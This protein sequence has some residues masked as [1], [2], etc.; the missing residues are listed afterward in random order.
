MFE[1]STSVSRE[2]SDTEQSE[3]NGEL[4]QQLFPIERHQSTSDKSFDVKRQR[5]D[6]IGHQQTADMST[7]KS[8]QSC[9]TDQTVMNDEHE[10]S[11]RDQSMAIIDVADRSFDRSNR[12]S[13]DTL[14]LDQSLLS[15]V[16]TL[17]LEIVDTGNRF[18]MSFI[19]HILDDIL[20][21][22]CSHEHS[23]L[24]NDEKQQLDTSD[25]SI[26]NDKRHNDAH[27]QNVVVDRVHYQVGNVV[28]SHH[29][30]ETIDSS[31]TISFEEKSD[32]NVF[33]SSNDDANAFERTYLKNSSMSTDLFHNRQ[34]SMDTTYYIPG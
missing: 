12:F 9:T 4:C 18:D 13:A 28:D 21:H 5:I 14:D 10:T 23:L 7:L 3:N 34:S 22:P 33:S 32:M 2:S 17:E 31:P 8:C 29:G 1:H 25:S 16:P 19:D 30:E 11:D 26:V 15:I 6:S 24:T 20:S 27:Q